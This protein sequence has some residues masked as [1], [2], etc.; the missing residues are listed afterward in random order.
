MR[1][2]KILGTGEYL[3]ET[4]VTNDDFSKIIETSNE[5]I[6]SR[7]G[8]RE[9]RFSAEKPNHEMAA[10]AAKEAVADSGVSPEEIDLILVSTCSHEFFYPNAACLVQEAIGAV[11]AAAYDIN[12]ACTGFIC[13]VD[14]ASRYLEDGDYRNILIVASERLSNHLDFEDRAS[15]VL[16]GDGAAAAVLTHSDK[17]FYSYLN[18][19]G[20][21]FRSLYCHIN[22]KPNC[23]FQGESTLG[24][25]LDTDKKRNYLQMDGRA[26]YKFAV[27]AMA[28]AMGRVL[29]KAGLSADDL[30]LVIPHQANIRIIQSAMKLMKLPDEKVYINIYDRANTS[31]VC[32]PTCLYELKKAGRL[33]ERMK[34]CLVG[35][36]A[37]LTSGAIIYET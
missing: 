27:D 9:R 6:E 11:N 13:A 35:F 34:I 1:G 5:W 24:E 28:A 12:A 2:I 15:C 21:P 37:G 33:K 16:F 26:V 18:A 22:T 20:D 4:V 23:P 30:D 36:G 29:D 19:K 31:S 3:P 10:E 8:I 14:I 32:I 25:L 7:T 17:P